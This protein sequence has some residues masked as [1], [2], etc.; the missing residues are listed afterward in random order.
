MTAT[1]K[2]TISERAKKLRSVL[3]DHYTRDDLTKSLSDLIEDAM[4]LCAQRG[5]NY[6]A[7]DAEAAG[8]TAQMYKEAR[9]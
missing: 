9:K 6:S 5:M 2:R 4:Y 1:A 3:R 8:R 7:L